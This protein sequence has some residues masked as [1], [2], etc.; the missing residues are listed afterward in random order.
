MTT[1]SNTNNTYSIIL[2]NEDKYELP[3]MLHKCISEDEAKV[4]FLEYRNAG[5]EVRMI[6]ELVRLTRY[7]SL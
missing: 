6:T 3:T 4:K 2:L 7:S 5:E 1:A